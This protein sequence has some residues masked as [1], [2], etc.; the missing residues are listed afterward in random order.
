MHWHAPTQRSQ[1]ITVY[2][3]LVLIA[4]F[5]SIGVNQRG[6]VPGIGRPDLDI[7]Y[8]LMQCAIVLFLLLCLHPFYRRSFHTLTNCVY[9][10]FCAVFLLL[11]VFLCFVYFDPFM[12]ILTIG[13]G[14]TEGLEMWGI[15]LFLK[16]IWL[17]TGGM[18]VVHFLL[19]R[20]TVT[21][22]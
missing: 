20:F 6:R 11:S 2:C 21:S 13:Y 7:E 17:V 3:A 9:L 8:I 1:K 5:V 22:K 10:F 19:W 15:Y 4:V 12:F 18:L 16:D 14:K